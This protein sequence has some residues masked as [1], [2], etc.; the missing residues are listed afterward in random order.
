MQIDLTPP[1]HT[2]FLKERVIAKP[3]NELEMMVRRWESDDYF[4]SYVYA[5]EELVSRRKLTGNDVGLMF[6]KPDVEELTDDETAEDVITILDNAG[7]ERKRKTVYTHNDTTY[8]R[9]WPSLR[10]PFPNTVLLT[11]KQW[12][13][14][15]YPELETYE[16][17]HKRLAREATDNDSYAG[18]D[19]FTIRF[20]SG[21]D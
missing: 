21:N 3:T 6:F 4:W 17:M 9:D 12:A 13:E 5:Q 16:E 1:K 11:N 14:R 8:M 15:N 10:S 2:A 18:T 19:N 20:G 7:A